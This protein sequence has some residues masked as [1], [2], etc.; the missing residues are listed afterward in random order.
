MVADDDTLIVD[1]LTD[2]LESA[3]HKVVHAYNSKD[4][5][6]KAASQRPDLVFLDLHMPGIKEAFENTVKIPDAIKNAPIV[7]VTGTS[8]Q[9]LAE[10]G[11]AKDFAVLKKPIE[12]EKLDA[13]LQKLQK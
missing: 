8:D 1:L 12:F 13:I 4:I 5:E 3:G 7:L 2:Y 10:L 11:L 9:K 6:E